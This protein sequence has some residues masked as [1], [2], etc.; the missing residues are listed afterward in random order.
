VL[1]IMTP[2]IV[3]VLLMS[4]IRGIE[5]FE[6]ELFLGVPFNFW[7]YS[8]KI[9]QLITH[10][11][12]AYALGGALA[13]SVLALM[14]P[15]IILQR[16]ASTR[17]SF[18]VV[19]GKYAARINRLGR[20][21]WPFF[22]LTAATVLCMSLL[23]LGL[24]LM[25]SFMKL[26]GFFGLNEMWTLDH[27]RETFGDVTFTLSFRNMLELGLGTSAL[28]VILYVFVAYCAVRLKTRWQAALDVLSWLPVS[29]PGI[30][31]GFGYLFMVIQVP[32][33]APLYGT[34]GVMIL[35]SLIAAMTLGVQ[36]MKVHMLQLGAEIEEAGR[37]AGASWLATFRNVI[38][39]MT[40]PAIAVVGVLVFAS[41]IRQIGSV[42]LLSTGETRVLA[43]LQLDF[44]TDGRLGPAS[45]VGA[46]I[47]L[48]SLIAA[49]IVRV[50]S[51]RF[52]V[53]A[54]PG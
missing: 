41:T 38:L 23:P 13:S 24:L 54:G 43:I 47:V 14:L 10:A 17:R 27:W 28:A 18:V 20:W 46:I 19:S 29:I 39:P 2:A 53:R 22:A 1:P 4:M 3:V 51:V 16:W 30:I 48:I 5:A 7:V 26:F 12:P 37:I 8:T 15:L 31:L 33:F 11:P 21:R 52:G 32:I 50:I 44:L 34:I 35:V 25:G 9:Y 45:V 42:I 40:S 6:I 36:V 49:A